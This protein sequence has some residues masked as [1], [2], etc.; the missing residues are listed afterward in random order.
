MNKY[1]FISNDIRN[2]ILYTKELKPN[3]L[4]PTETELCKKYLAS[5]MTIKRALDIL[6]E[7]GLIYKKRGYGSF[8]K[9]LPYSHI[10]SIISSNKNR[11]LLGFSEEF[12]TKNITT[13]VIKYTIIESNDN[14]SSKLEISKGDFVYYIIRIHFVDNIAV[15][16]EKTY[17]PIDIIPKLKR[18][19]A[20][21]SIYSYIENTLGLEIQSAH[22]SIK[23]IK[24]DKFISENL[25][26]N[27]D[28]PIV[29]VVQIAFL[30]NGNIFEYSIVQHR[31]EYY[32]FNDVIVKKL[33]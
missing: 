4:L 19:D 18:H 20:E 8:V 9:G 29:E 12:K 30:T 7:E 10:K 27:I 15:C 31:Y 6:V 24:S 22:M 16:L 14:I 25:N 11:H 17:M 26:I 5:K 3:E 32:E 21:N 28:E 13:T 23:A 33:K 1:T 2:K